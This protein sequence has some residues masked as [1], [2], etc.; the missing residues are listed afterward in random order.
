V[1]GGEDLGK[2]FE[3]QGEPLRVARIPFP[4]EVARLESLGWRKV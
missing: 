1:A 2:H 3:A 4:Q